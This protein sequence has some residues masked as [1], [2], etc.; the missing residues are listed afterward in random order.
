MKNFKSNL[1]AALAYAQFG[2]A[3]FPVHYILPNGSCSC[4]RPNCASPGKHPRT[5]NGLKA[6]TL[7]VNQ[8][9]KWWT[10]TPDANVAIATGTPSNLLVLD[11]DLKSGGIESLGDLLAEYGDITD[12]STVQTGGGGFHYYFTLPE[13][14]ELKNSAGSLRAGLDIR[15]ENGYV[16]APPSNH[17]KGTNYVWI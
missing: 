13:G 11:V 8:I 9:T 14:Q 17:S 7:D 1:E 5:S 3:V 12:T 10:Q 15:A 2:W 6:A 16:V 4:G